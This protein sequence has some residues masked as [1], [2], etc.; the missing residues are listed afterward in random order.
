M[1]TP[2]HPTHHQVR[3]GIRR[4]SGTDLNESV[5]FEKA[6][7]DKLKG[8]REAKLTKVDLSKLDSSGW[9]VQFDDTGKIGRVRMS[10]DLGI[11]YLPNGDLKNGFLYP[12]STLKVKVATDNSGRLE[13]IISAQPKDSK[14][15]VGSTRLHQGDSDVIIQNNRILLTSNNILINGVAGV[16]NNMAFV[17]SDSPDALKPRATYYCDGTTDAAIIQGAIDAHPEGGLLDFAPGTYWFE[18]AV[19]IGPNFTVHGA[20]DSTV[21]K[22][23]NGANSSMFVNQGIVTNTKFMFI[24]FNGNRVNQTTLNSLISLYNTQGCTIQN[25]QF[26]DAL[27]AGIELSASSNN[28][29]TALNISNCGESTHL[30]SAGIKIIGGLTNSITNCNI[31]NNQGNGIYSGAS[32]GLK[33]NTVDARSNQLNGY[34][35][36]N[37]QYALIQNSLF[38]SNGQKATITHAHGISIWDGLYNSYTGNTMTDYNNSGKKQRLGIS[39]TNNSGDIPGPDYMIIKDNILIENG[40]GSIATYGSNNK[41]SDNIE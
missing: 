10:S 38:E 17:A 14:A 8:I 20:G 29:L 35:S 22:L 34:F 26:I 4:I 2:F 36:N 19:T 9:Y 32:K 41:I 16:A 30:D 23:K 39:M 13:H 37:D 21:F 24:K 33:I 3:K 11:A 18:K 25:S 27:G 6:P 7:M 5:G 28:L 12:S 40:I 15:I 1:P 31:S